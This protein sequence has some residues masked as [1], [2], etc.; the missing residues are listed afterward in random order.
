MAEDTK[1]EYTIQIYGS[2]WRGP[3]D[4]ELQAAMNSLG[5]Q[6]WEV[7][8]AAQLEGSSKVR[9]VAK[10]PLTAAARRRSAWPG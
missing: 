8:W 6:G 1:W 4:E 3:K 10:R 7:F 9:I 5:E 2:T